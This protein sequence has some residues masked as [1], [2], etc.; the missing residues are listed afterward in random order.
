MSL[1]WSE[2]M[3]CRSPWLFLRCSFLLLLALL[4]VAPAGAQEYSFSVPQLRM[5][6][7][8]QEDA[9]VRITYDITFANNPG[10]R[11]IDVVDIGVPHAGYDL[12]NMSASLEGVPL[13]DIRPSEYVTPGVEVHLGNQAIPPG[14]ERRFHFEFTM[15]EMVYQ[16]TTRE[17]YASLQITP[18]WFGEEFVT[19]TTYLQIAVV[20][21]P[22]IRPDEVLY[23]ETP[24]DNKVEYAGGT[25]VLW[26]WT[27][28]KAT[29]PRLVGLSFPKR[30]LSRV[31]QISRFELLVRRFAESP[32]AR[33]WAGVAS[34]FLLALL[35]FRFTGG[36]GCVLFV[37]LFIAFFI[38]ISA[39]PAA[40]LL[41]FAPLI[42]LVLW[43]EWY[44]ARR[45]RRYLPPVAQVEGGGVLRGLSPAEAAVLL[46]MPLKKVLLLVLFGLLRKGVLREVRSSPWELE[47]VEAFRT[48]GAGLPDRKA[49]RLRAA[50][51]TG[52]VI[53]P[54]EHAFLDV[55]E[56][57]R[58]KPI[59]A[60]DFGGAMKKLI[61]STVGK[62]EGFDLS[63]TQ[64]YY[65]A[66][67]A[68][69]LAEAK[70]AVQP[71]ERQ[72]AIDRN[73]EWI[74][75]DRNPGP[76]FTG[77][78]Y[79][80]RPVWTRRAGGEARAPQAPPEEAASTPF[81]PS[82]QG[83][84][85]E[86]AASTSFGV[87]RPQ[88]PGEEAASTSFAGWREGKGAGAASTSFADWADQTAEELSGAI[89]SGSVRIEGARG[90]IIDLSAADRA[91]ADLFEALS[92]SSGGGG[93]GGGGGCV[94]ACAC[95]GCA[96]ACACAGG[97]R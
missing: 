89:P 24:F 66:R 38:L 30:G 48:Y 57:N 1:G 28:A 68:H 7:Q 23:Q 4:C 55:L 67:V 12:A 42:V 93:G 26:R 73:L 17:D 56:K 13:T 51:D 40:H 69:A 92:E 44:L 14:G 9:S 58:G 18:T 6:V 84:A 36:T 29:G 83:R 80:Y 97:G 75:L 82:Q 74:L 86:G 39:S 52:G 91:T 19:G 81:S 59:Q 27:D 87:S 22:G 8:V 61:E 25:A 65:R 16:D 95:A 32:G 72:S 78:G 50:R 64:D 21:L 71:E 35:Y 3:H 31:V 88:A 94:C 34:L 60:I 85:G 90:G 53:H 45:R 49:E 63:D 41:S 47:V 10:A 96:C 62:M 20:T 77:G 37:P 2:R 46:E 79:G 5:Q 11:A 54:Y 15:P 33:F 70:A 43:N 76:I